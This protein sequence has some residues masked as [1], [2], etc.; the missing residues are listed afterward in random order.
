[1]RDGKAVA[2]IRPRQLATIRVELHRVLDLRDS[3]TRAAIG[4]SLE[5]LMADDPS[6]A[7]AIGEAAQHLGYEAIVAPSAAG[8]PGHVVALF[9]P[10]RAADSSI[11]L[12][13]VEP[14]PHP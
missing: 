4:V 11:E 12:V 2:G 14:Y 8:G 3:A 10:N 5:D 13:S 6:L 9:M 7:Q 1:M